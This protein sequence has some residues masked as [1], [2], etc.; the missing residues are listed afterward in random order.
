M[1]IDWYARATARELVP[2]S[3]RVDAAYLRST[4]DVIRLIE[5]EPQQNWHRG[6]A[7]IMEHV[8]HRLHLA[9]TALFLT[10]GCITVLELVMIAV[11]HS[12]V[13]AGIHVIERPFAEAATFFCAVLPALGAAISGIRVQADF[14]D[15]SERSHGMAR[16]LEG[17]ANTLRD[18]QELDFASVSTLAQAAAETMLTDIADWRFV[19]R[20]KSLT[21]PS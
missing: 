9:G 10:T 17:I 19:F 2:P 8:A 20:G 1:W 14:E 3:R 15:V 16:H 11:E 12:H 7:R 21:L 5:V 18:R 13:W 6:N 4:S